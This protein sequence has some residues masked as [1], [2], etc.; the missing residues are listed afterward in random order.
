MP[1][2]DGDT[3]EMGRWE[4]LKQRLVNVR[5]VLRIACV[6]NLYHTTVT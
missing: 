1:E 5:S 2:R 4:S 3:S 6:S